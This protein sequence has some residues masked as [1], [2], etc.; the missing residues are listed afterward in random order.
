MTKREPINVGNT[1]EISIQNVANMIANI[2]EY[3]GRLIW[4]VNQPKGQ[5]R[6]PS[7]NKK[8]IEM[9]WNLNNYTPMLQGLKNTCDWFVTNYPN[10]RGL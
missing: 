2:L 9:G 10:V 1:K 4:D 6:K 3:D 8:L 5:L 7:D